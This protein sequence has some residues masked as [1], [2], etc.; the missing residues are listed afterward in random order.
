MAVLQIN[1]SS[2]DVN[3]E[4]YMTNHAQWNPDVAAELAKG[5]GVT[6]TPAHWRV[7]NFIDKDFGEKGV[8]P[9]IRRMNKVGGIPT[10]ELYDLFP[11]GPIKKAA[12]ISGYP[13][14]A[15]CV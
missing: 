12:K 5:L 13:K 11:E 8:V 3:D 4:G 10:K 15:S 2:I 14:P 7:L 1:G 9:G 6:L